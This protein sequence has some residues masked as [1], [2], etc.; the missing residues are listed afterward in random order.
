MHTHALKKKKK[1]EIMGGVSMV[2]KKSI[3]PTTRRWNAYT[4]FM[5]SIMGLASGL[6]ALLSS[7]SMTSTPSCSATPTAHGRH[8]T[9][10]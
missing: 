8:Q 7:S 2:V 10:A 9:T 4:M 5:G 1:K 6:L 3:D